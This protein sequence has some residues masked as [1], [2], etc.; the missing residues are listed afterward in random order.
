MNL[1]WQTKRNMN[2]NKVLEPPLKVGSGKIVV[3]SC[4]SQLAEHDNG[5][6]L[7]LQRSD[8]DEQNQVT[9]S[10]LKPKKTIKIA[11]FNMRTRKGTMENQ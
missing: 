8:E 6:S 11:T 4:S 1:Y 10:I 9:T 3:E 5:S 7:N 2:V